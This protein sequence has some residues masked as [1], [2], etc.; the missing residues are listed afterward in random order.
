MVQHSRRDM[1]GVSLDQSLL[2][3][4]GRGLMVEAA[5]S[6]D[7]RQSGPAGQ[8]SVLKLATATRCPDSHSE[9]RNRG[10]RRARRFSQ[11]VPALTSALPVLQYD[12]DPRAM[13]QTLKWDIELMN[14]A[15]GYL[16][17]IGQRWEQSWVFEI[18]MMGT[19]THQ[20]T[21]EYI[22]ELCSDLIPVVSSNDRVVLEEPPSSQ[23][24]GNA[25]GVPP[26]GRLSPVYPHE[27][28]L[29]DSDAAVASRWFGQASGPTQ[30]WGG[31]RKT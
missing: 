27:D 19:L 11:E 28:R 8:L 4:T 18:L 2:S 16:G 3:A 15:G 20:M 13:V 5:V 9:S 1:A 26:D 29:L 31:S 14:L 6:L 22:E 17:V 25:S 10:R 23:R 7:S 30:G 21:D 24:E 12:G